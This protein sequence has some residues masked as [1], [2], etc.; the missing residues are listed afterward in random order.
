MSRWR[1]KVASDPDQYLQF[2]APEDILLQKLRWYRIGEEVSDREWRDARGILR[3]Q[4]ERLDLPYLERGATALG[5]A[6][7]LQ[8]ARE[9]SRQA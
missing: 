8:R 3:V 9:Q 6:D 1:V 5:V 4:G 2:Y 7:L